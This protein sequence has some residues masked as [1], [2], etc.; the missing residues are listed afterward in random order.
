MYILLEIF[1]E[2]NIIAWHNRTYKNKFYFCVLPRKLFKAYC[3]K[4]M[5]FRQPDVY[6]KKEKNF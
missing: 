2:F 3:E 6:V 1:H 4:Q 5:V